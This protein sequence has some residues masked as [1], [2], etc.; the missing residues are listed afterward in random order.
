[1]ILNWAFREAEFD[2]YDLEGFASQE[3]KGLN[4]EI[5]VGYID[6]GEGCW[7]RNM[8]VTTLRG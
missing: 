4:Y 7:R 1:M 6:V 5:I 2:G 8:L 3:I